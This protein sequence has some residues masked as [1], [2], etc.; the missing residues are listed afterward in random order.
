MKKFSYAIVRKPCK[1]LVDGISTAQFVDP[2]EK[3][4]YENAVQQHAEYVKTL[5]ALGAKVLVLEADEDYP[6]S[7]FTED[8]AVV[9]DGCQSFQ[10][11]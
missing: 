5:E 2:G 9:M 8:P 1:A 10:K 11:R 7:V 3:P 6:D 4:I